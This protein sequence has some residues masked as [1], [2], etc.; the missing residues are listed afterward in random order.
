[1]ARVHKVVANIFWLLEWYQL[2]SWGC[3]DAAAAFFNQIKISHFTRD[4]LHALLSQAC[5]FWL[6]FFRE[7]KKYNPFQSSLLTSKPDFFVNF[8]RGLCTCIL[9]F[10]SY[11]IS[12]K[13]FL[14]RNY[15]GKFE[16]EKLDFCCQP[17][18]LILGYLQMNSS[19]A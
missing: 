8:V 19:G 1:M 16:K 2:H 14:V 7:K 15:F 4:S 3:Q 10:Y 9:I 5:L 13:L 12:E 17:T 6:G 11:S 18:C